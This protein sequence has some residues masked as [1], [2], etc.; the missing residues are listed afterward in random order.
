M[1]RDN[2]FPGWWHGESGLR[3]RKLGSVSSTTD[4]LRD[5]L[6]VFFISTLN[7][8]FVLLFVSR[9]EEFQFR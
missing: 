1:I 8:A 9:S 4:D 2:R 6:A 3:G 7:A 5:L